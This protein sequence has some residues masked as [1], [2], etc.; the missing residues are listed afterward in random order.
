[1]T[2]FCKIHLY[3]QRLKIITC[4]TEPFYNVMTVF[5]F[6]LKVQWEFSLLITCTSF[7]LSHT[8]NSFIFWSPFQLFCPMLS[9]F[10]LPSCLHQSFHC[11]I[12]DWLLIGDHQTTVSANRLLHAVTGYVFPFQNALWAL[13]G[14]C[15]STAVDFCA[16]N[17]SKLLMYCLK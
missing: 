14:A 12:Q 15:R 11:P 17:Y 5:Q 3:M 6:P 13:D 2:C 16:V 8:L 7:F 10:L 1:M 4:F 9:P